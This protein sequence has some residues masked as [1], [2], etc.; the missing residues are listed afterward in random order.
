MIYLLIPE[1]E[2]WEGGG[3]R[4]KKRDTLTEGQ[5]HNPGTCPDQESN[6]RP[7]GLPDNAPTN[8][9]HQPGQDGQ[10]K[11]PICLCSFLNSHEN[12]RKEFFFF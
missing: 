11:P 5:T 8:W 4:E 3:E 1:R 10:S 6:Q 2:E 9:A 12:N 7:F